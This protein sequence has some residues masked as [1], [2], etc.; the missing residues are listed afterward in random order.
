MPTFKVRFQ[1]L[2]VVTE[3]SAPHSRSTVMMEAAELS[4]EQFHQTARRHIQKTGGITRSLPP[5]LAWQTFRPFDSS[6]NH[7]TALHTAANTSECW[8]KKRH[9]NRVKSWK[10]R[11]Y[12]N[13]YR[14]IRSMRNAVLWNVT[15]CNLIEIYRL[16]YAHNAVK[17]EEAVP[18][19]ASHTRRYSSKSPPRHP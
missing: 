1:I 5:P 14:H 6:Q 7:F 13:T 18:Y 12:S 19:T 9:Q 16:S 3:V 15:P 2:T 11:F 8:T 10:H 4:H 17:L